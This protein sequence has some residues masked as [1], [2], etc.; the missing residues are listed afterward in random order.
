MSARPPR[1]GGVLG[2][3]GQDIELDRG[4]CTEWTVES[5][6]SMA[7]ISSSTAVTEIGEFLTSCIFP[8]ASI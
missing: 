6:F 3:T 5:L 7:N 8:S 4:E 2:G 1:R